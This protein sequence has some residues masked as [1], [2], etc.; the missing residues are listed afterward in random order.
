M[1]YDFATN[2]VCTHQVF[3][4]KVSL[5]NVSHQTVNFP[6][7]PSNLNDIAVYIDRVKVPKTGL[8]SY[9]ELPLLSSEPYRIKVNQNDLIYLSIGSNSPQFY[10]LIPGSNVSAKDLARHLQKLFPNLY[11]YVQNKRVV[12]RSRER[13]NGKAFQFHNPQWTDTTSS[14]PTTVRTLAAYTTLGINPGRIAAGRRLFPGWSIERVPTSPIDTDRRIKFNDPLPNSIPLIEINYTTDA[15]NCRRCHGS[16]MEFDYA[17]LNNTYE[18]VRDVNLLAQEFD[19]FLITKIGS[20]WKWPW[21]GSGL[22]D[23]I[24]GKGSTGGI[25]ATSL[26]TVDVNQAFKTYQNIKQQQEQGFPQAQVSDGEFPLKLANLDVQSLPNDPTVAIV[27]GTIVS[28][29][30]VPVENIRVV[31]DPSPFILQNDPVSRL[32][33]TTGLRFRG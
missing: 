6:F 20:H 28:R 3:F 2:Q 26:I 16:K 5:N 12:F 22:V 33:I 19:K 4:E 21:L 15:R 23:R 10:Q 30:R 9:A 8:Y 27:A 32:A 1:S 7:T 14:L 31:G 25:S 18:E 13:V 29:S 17:I 11:I 24:G